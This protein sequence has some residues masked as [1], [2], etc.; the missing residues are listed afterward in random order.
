MLRRAV[1]LGVTLIDTADSYG[2]FVAE[3]LI[4]E[5]LAPYPDDLVIATKAGLTRSRT[6]RL[7]TRRVVPSTSASSST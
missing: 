4:H 1:E 6:E 5:A 2:P 7:A 3:E